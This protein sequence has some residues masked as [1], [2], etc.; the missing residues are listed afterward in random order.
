MP[1]TPPPRDQTGKTT[2]HD[3]AEIPDDSGIIRR[4]SILQTTVGANGRRRISSVAY[5]A[6]EGDGEGMSVDIEASILM[7][8]LDAVTHVTTPRWIGSVQFRAGQLRGENLQVGFD[9]ITTP[10]PN[11]HHGQVW[12]DFPDSKK[13][14][15]ARIATWFVPIPDVD[16]V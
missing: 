14:R 9:P 7:A 8:G 11:P 6:S 15:L 4:I 16:L 2:P 13:R 12:G 1:L 3:H 5:K 10:E